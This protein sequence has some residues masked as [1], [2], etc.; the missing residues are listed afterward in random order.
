MLIEFF[1]AECPHCKA[2]IPL[3][4]KLEKEE[5]VIVER[6]EVWNN[7]AN[8]KKMQEFDNGKCGGVPFFI[9]TENSKFI[10]GAADYAELK[11]WAT[12]K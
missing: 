11:K 1:G 4:E 2:M 5:N 8:L 9:N 7:E 6:H 10:C 3:V 12:E